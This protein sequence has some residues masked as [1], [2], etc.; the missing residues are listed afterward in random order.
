METRGKRRKS[1][2]QFRTWGADVK[3][4]LNHSALTNHP[5]WLDR[6]QHAMGNIHLGL[7]I[8]RLELKEVCVPRTPCARGSISIPG[9]HFAS[10]EL[11][12]VFLHIRHGDPSRRCRSRGGFLYEGITY[13]WFSE[14]EAS[15]YVAIS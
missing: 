2:V 9:E 15:I 1:K 11:Q 10:K 6:H 5:S 14:E 3:C 7:A 4:L 12:D 13:S 8:N